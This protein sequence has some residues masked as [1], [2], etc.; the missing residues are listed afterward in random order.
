M[1]AGADNDVVNEVQEVGANV[2]QQVLYVDLGQ[3]LCASHHTPSSTVYNLLLL[4]FHVC[5]TQRLQRIHHIVQQA[6]SQRQLDL[7]RRETAVVQET[8]DLG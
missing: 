4:G 7:F 2:E 3:V 5:L 8:R 1:S 6:Q